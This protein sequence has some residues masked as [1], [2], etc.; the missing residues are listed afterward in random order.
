MDIVF[1]T[2]A[3]AG[4][5]CAVVSLTISAGLAVGRRDPDAF[6]ESIPWGYAGVGLGLAAVGFGVARLAVDR[7]VPHVQDPWGLFVVLLVASGGYGMARALIDSPR[8]GNLW[9][10]GLS[11][12]LGLAGGLSAV[13]V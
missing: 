4:I 11:L 3:V 1:Y 12:A 8:V 5:L 13:A 6:T 10:L 9:P 7:T 2:L